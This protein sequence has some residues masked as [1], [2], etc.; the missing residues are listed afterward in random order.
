MERLVNTAMEL[1]AFLAKMILIVIWTGIVN[2]ESV[3][4][5]SVLYLQE[6]L[7]KMIQ[8]V[9]LKV[10]VLSSNVSPFAKKIMIAVEIAFASIASAFQEFVTKTK[11][12]VKEISAKT[13]IVSF[14]VMTIQT[15]LQTRIALKDFASTSL[16][17]LVTKTLIVVLM[18]TVFKVSV[19]TGVQK[20]EDH[21]LRMK[22]AINTNAFQEY[23]R[24]LLIVPLQVLNVR[25]ANVSLTA[26]K[27]PFALME[28]NAIMEL[29]WLVM[30]VL[31]ITNLNVPMGI[32]IEEGAKLAALEIE[33]ALP[34]KCKPH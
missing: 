25:K 29:A 17:T 13:S 34:M 11:I 19:Q 10:D 9:G 27:I 20:V 8:T 30:V 21:V 33:I 15:V 3:M 14:V 7:V 23:A 4:M 5:E 6:V 28:W 31:V 1:N 22:C 24:R 32:V 2:L 12:V 18:A 16:K 26:P